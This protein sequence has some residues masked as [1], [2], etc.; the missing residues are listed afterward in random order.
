LKVFLEKRNTVY[1]FLKI[2]R[3]HSAWSYA[4]ASLVLALARLLPVRSADE[5]KKHRYFLQRLARA[6]SGLLRGEPLGEWFGPPLGSWDGH[7]S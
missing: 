1:W 3:R 7:V 4:Q 2:G 6:F 5:R